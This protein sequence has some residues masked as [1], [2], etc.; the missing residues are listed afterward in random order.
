MPYQLITYQHSPPHACC[1]R[2]AGPVEQLCCSSE[3]PPPCLS[4]VRSQGYRLPNIAAPQ[5]MLHDF[6]H[7][8]NH[9]SFYG[10]GY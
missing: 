5:A 2:Q 8:E 9:E 4:L 10:P 7:P 1:A 3:L 6:D